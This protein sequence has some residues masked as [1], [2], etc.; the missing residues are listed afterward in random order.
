M[1]PHVKHVTR[2]HNLYKIG[3]GSLDGATLMY[4]ISN[5][6]SMPYDFRQEDFQKSLFSP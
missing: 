2:R 1:Q 4:Q 5:Q 6:G 3:K